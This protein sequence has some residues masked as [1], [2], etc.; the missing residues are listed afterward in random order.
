MFEDDDIGE[1]DITK[2]F[3]LLYNSTPEENRPSFTKSYPIEHGT[4]PSSTRSSPADKHKTERK[5]CQESVILTGK[6]SRIT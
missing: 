5:D 1:P 2:G 4:L 3:N 6:T